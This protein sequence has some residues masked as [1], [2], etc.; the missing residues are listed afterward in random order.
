MARRKPSRYN[1]LL[2]VAKV[3]G[4][5]S[6]DVVDIA[7]RALGERRIG[8]TWT[9]DPMAEG[10]L[11]LC[12]GN[13]TRLQ[14]YL[15]DWDK[16]YTGTILLGTA[17]QTYDREGESMDPSGPA[18]DLHE[19]E[20]AEIAQSFSG[21]IQQV[22]P[23]YSAKKVGGK[24]LYELAREGEAIL[25][26]PKTVHVHDL[27]L[28]QREPGVLEFRVR[29]SSGFYVRS[30]AHDIGV[31]LGCGGHLGSLKR[32]AIGPYSLDSALTQAA[33]ESA[34]TPETVVG[35]PAWVALEDV[36]LPH[37][38]V[39]LNPAAVER[40]LHGG[41][42]IVLHGEGGKVEQGGAVVLRDREGRLLGLGTVATLLARGRTLAIRPKTVLAGR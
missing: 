40:F 42:V 31:R 11:L 22:P 37:L 15:L 14:Q 32:V 35:S 27:E 24:K 17:T 28:A 10:L 21:E 33:L 39:M 2:P 36:R 19:A 9:L 26:E 1:G 4:P 8:H 7:R 20:L 25:V 29:T 6:H 34:D 23:P 5:T 18:P 12:V 3:S 16:A 38:E 41:E 30:L 13:A